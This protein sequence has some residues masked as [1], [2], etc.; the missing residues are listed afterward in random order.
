MFCVLIFNALIRSIQIATGF[1][2]HQHHIPWTRYCGK[3]LDVI[4]SYVY[5]AITYT[6]GCL[7]HGFVSRSWHISNKTKLFS[8]HLLGI[9][10]AW[11]INMFPDSSANG[12]HFTIP[13]GSRV[14]VNK[15]TLDSYGKRSLDCIY[16]SPISNL[17]INL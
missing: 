6:G 3:L 9:I 15:L 11:V 17:I 8:N 12:L 14:Y 5:T 16:V 10:S 2:L 4:R 13:S 7:C 1:F